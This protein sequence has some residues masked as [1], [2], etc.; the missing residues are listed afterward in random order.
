MAAAVFLLCLASGLAGD[1]LLRAALLGEERALVRERMGPYANA[2]ESAVGR[3]MSAVVGLKAF[4]EVR[5]THPQFAA[6]FEAY[7]AA[8]EGTIPGLRTLQYS[9]DG[10][11]RQTWP[12]EGNEAIVGL[13]LARHPDPVIRRDYQRALASQTLVLSGPLELGQGGRGLVGRIAARDPQGRIL[14]VVAAV[15][16]LAPLLA[17]S[18]LDRTESL[19]LTLFDGEGHALTGSSAILQ[20]TPVE[21]FVNLPDRRWT[22]AARPFVGWGSSGKTRVNWY[23]LEAGLFAV[24]LAALAFAVLKA[25]EA[26]ARESE[27]RFHDLFDVIPDAATLTRL[28]DD[29]I[30]QIN[31]GFPAMLGSHRDEIVGRRA[32]DL[33]VWAVA[34][35]RAGVLEAVKRSGVVIG[36]RDQLRRKDGTVREVEV[37]FKVLVVRGERCM[38]S[39]VRDVTEARKVERLLV[40]SQ[41]LEAIGTLAGGVAHD[42][43][44]ILTVILSCAQLAQ[45]EAPE[46]ASVRADLQTIMEASTRA[47]ALTR[48]LLSFARRQVVLPRKVDV[49]QVVRQT[50]TLL[51]RVIPANIQLKTALAE[52]LP[53]VL[54]DP[55]QLEQVLM[56]LAV[57]A[58]DAM[59][60]GGHLTISTAQVGSDL[61]LEL[62]DTGTG[63][64]RELQSRIFEPF[65]TSKGPGKGTGLGLATSYGI[66]RQAGGRLEFES[67]P[68][69][70]TRFRV[71]LPCL[72][73]DEAIPDAPAD[74][75]GRSRGGSESVLLVEDEPLVRASTARMLR[76]LGYRVLEA[77]D[78]RE[79][80]AIARGALTPVA[81]LVTDVMMPDQGGRALAT[82][83]TKERPALRVLFVS[84]Y[85]EA[86]ATI[87]ALREGAGFLAKP[88]QQE[89]LAA[90][91]R[92]VL[93]EPA[94]PAPPAGK[95]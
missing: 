4:F 48:Q 7:A 79:A 71:V 9:L 50:L 91:L 19:A 81:V 52:P 13:D 80:L 37:S 92:A 23:R 6:D 89:D 40:E 53:P 39:I 72:S 85:S 35:S 65:F 25:Q 51:A 15:L 54:V 90:A 8:V 87:A 24:L 29:I 3:R 21:A 70:G 28:S 64:P 30:L 63:I 36:W 14:A 49:N 69:Q 17:E 47:A 74:R 5:S 27:A 11:I 67:Q 44:N 31:D 57:N 94:P 26:R 73:G 93:D 12:R 84:G 20:E 75:E 95:G 77:K 78:G 32:A 60:E 76:G 45:G 34:E 86:D 61:V 10:I 18:R 58:R 82:Q 22:L 42:F 88:F 83:L 46:G 33:G 16:D 66:I 62:R 68:G 41:K 59:P 38:V 43:N 56:N 1:R 55:G 2:L